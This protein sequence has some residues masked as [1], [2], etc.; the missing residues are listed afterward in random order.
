MEAFLWT[1]ILSII[2]ASSL[3]ILIV[4]LTLVISTILGAVLA[5]LSVSGPRFLKPFLMVYSWIGRSLPPLT[6]LYSVYFGMGIA[7]VEMGNLTAATVAY[8]FF[9]TAYIFEI[10][11]GSYKAIPRAQFEAAKALGLPL[12]ATELRVV[13]PQVI[14]LSA[15]AY[16]TNAT[17]VLKE[18]SLASV[19]GVAEATSVT[20]RLVQANPDMALALFGILGVIY[21]VLG[22]ILLYFGGLFDR[23]N[24]KMYAPA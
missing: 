2:K 11:R 13:W 24:S 3:T 16:L 14:R 5:P 4:F 21:T 22:S 20:V 7:G 15:P 8:I 17:T 1:S 6:L 19:I 18:S 12:W 10:F 23:R 9:S